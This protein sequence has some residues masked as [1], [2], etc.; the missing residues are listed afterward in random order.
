MCLKLKNAEFQWGN[1]FNVYSNN[2]HVIH[3]DE[4]PR[5]LHL[6]HTMPVET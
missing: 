6:V 4:L 1:V 3:V 5:V 2:T